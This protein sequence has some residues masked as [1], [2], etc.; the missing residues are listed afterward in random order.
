MRQ[1]INIQKTNMDTTCYKCT[2]YITN[3]FNNWSLSGF[4]PIQWLHFQNYIF[5]LVLLLQELVDGNI[6]LTDDKHIDDGGVIYEMP[7]VLDRLTAIYGF[8]KDEE[9][10][11]A[12]SKFFFDSSGGAAE[13]EGSKL[14][15]LILETLDEIW[16]SQDSEEFEEFQ[17][18]C[19]KIISN[20]KTPELCF[21]DYV[22]D[23]GPLNEE[24]KLRAEALFRPESVI[25]VPPGSTPADI[26]GVPT[27]AIF[28]TFSTIKKRKVKFPKT[29]RLTVERKEAIPLKKS[30]YPPNTRRQLKLK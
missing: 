4:S 2:Q 14:R 3:K 18:S 21:Y 27:K 30:K 17:L 24:W 28:S 29:R 5:A 15:T 11:V 6:S 12:A 10:A 23:S 1:I 26:S 8:W 13:G 20:C 25:Y 16:L 19:E 7:A 22:V 9:A